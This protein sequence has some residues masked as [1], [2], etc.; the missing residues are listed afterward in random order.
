M[1]SRSKPDNVPKPL[2]AGPTGLSFIGPEVVVSGDV[3]TSTQLHVEGR[4]DGHVRCAQLC[5]GKSGIVAGNIDAEEARIAGLVE[6]TVFA[7]SLTLESTAR[8]KGDI[9]Y[10]T[11]IVAAGAQ[12][13][14]RL[15]RRDS[16]SPSEEPAPLLTATPLVEAK[17]RE[18]EAVEPEDIFT[19]TPPRQA[20]AG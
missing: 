2:K 1:F 6:G 4:I 16:L 12:V 20:A 18:A 19:L 9:T 11:I 13:D 15:A 10:Q 5:Q 7:G 14:G 17:S 3:S 8:I